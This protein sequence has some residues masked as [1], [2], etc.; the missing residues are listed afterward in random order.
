M[1]SSTSTSA[2]P[3]AAYADHLGALEAILEAFRRA[4]VQWAVFVR[5]GDRSAHHE[6][7]VPLDPLGEARMA[8][9]QEIGRHF[10]GL[11]GLLVN[12]L[13]DGLPAQAIPEVRAAEDAVMDVAGY[14]VDGMPDRLE[15][16]E[17]GLG[18]RHAY[19]LVNEAAVK[20]ANLR[21]W[22]SCLLD[23][24]R[25]EKPGRPRN[26][27]RG[28]SPR[29]QAQAGNA[30]PPSKVADLDGPSDDGE[31][32]CHKGESVTVSR[33]TFRFAKAIWHVGHVSFASLR[34]AVSPDDEVLDGTIHTWAHRFK[35]ET[36][37]LNLPWTVSVDKRGEVVRKVQRMA[38]RK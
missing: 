12:R 22:R 13:P 20:L 36:S 29:G 17:P 25:E 4:L 21:R 8:A 23:D 15:E 7:G 5:P 26:P 35:E 18:F 28:Q 19:R 16:R 2:T 27:L 33:P 3:A 31:T 37:K 34:K 14:V 38:P 11:S 32:I 30:K 6:L 10:G 24:G 9:G 1:S